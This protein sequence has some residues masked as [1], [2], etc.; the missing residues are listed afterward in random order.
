MRDRPDQFSFM[1]MVAHMPI[2][3]VGVIWIAGADDYPTGEVIALEI[4]D[5]IFIHHRGF[6]LSG[7][8]T[9]VGVDHDSAT[10]LGRNSAILCGKAISFL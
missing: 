9:L 7:V 1:D 6:F 10:D 5:S 3:F 4:V 2:A 8:M